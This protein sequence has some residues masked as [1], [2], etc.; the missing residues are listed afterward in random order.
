[1]N[2]I[3]SLYTRQMLKVLNYALMITL[4]TCSDIMVVL[5]EAVVIALIMK[6]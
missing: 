2:L 1:M 3:E 6:G 4:L 5:T